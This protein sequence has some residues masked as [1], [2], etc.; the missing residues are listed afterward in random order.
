MKLL[1]IF[2]IFTFSGCDGINLLNDDSETEQ[3]EEHKYPDDRITFTLNDKQI[4]H[5]ADGTIL[6]NNCKLVVIRYQTLDKETLYRQN[7]SMAILF[8]E[9]KDTYPLYFEYIDNFDDDRIVHNEYCSSGFNVGAV[10]ME[11]DWDA[12][13]GDYHPKKEAGDVNK[14]TVTD[15]D[16]EAGEYGRLQGEFETTLY[17]KAQSGDARQLPDTL[18]IEGSFDVHL[19]WF[20]LG[21]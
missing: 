4:D 1:L 10:F 14:L 17:H 7:F 9:N 12:P 18:E 8:N 5:H 13:V 2:L 21:D 6:P 15:Y 20:E 16:P 11:V 3:E 19:Q